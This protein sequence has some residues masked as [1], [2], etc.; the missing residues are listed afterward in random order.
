MPYFHRVDAPRVLSMGLV[1][2]DVLC[3][4]QE[5]ERTSFR[6]GGTAGNVAA[7]LGALGWP[8]TLAGPAEESLA[9]E[10]M[11]NDLTRC[12]V[13]Y[14]E[15]HRA[16][17][18]VIVEELEH[19]ARHSFTFDCPAC[20]KALP[21]YHRT[22]RADASSWVC[23][24]VH[25]DVFF[26][27]RLSDEILELAQ[28]AR[29]SNA[30]I[31]YEP[32]DPSDAPWAPAMLALADMVKYSDERADGLSWLSDGDHLEVRTKGAAG[33][34]WRWARHEIHQW[35]SMASIHVANVVDT[36]GA[37]DW[38]TSGIL[39][40]L[41]ERGDT[42]ATWSGVTAM[43]QVLRRAQQLAAWSCGYAGARG[44]LYESGPA[45]A[46]AIVQHLETSVMPDPLPESNAGF[47]CAACPMTS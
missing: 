15:M 11:L 25:T 36:C 2:L 26:A 19:Y 37:G 41:L 40:G 31:V 13:E 4:A 39:I 34:Q 23:E 5:P 24:D 21:R 10:L 1:A 29:R 14:R 6:A 17:V 27:D 38:L 43:E 44:A 18:P 20:G 35:Q 12:G 22:Y 45:V 16:A 42:R 30:F 8:A 9:Y 3:I 32:S 46:R 28:S 7:I 33:L 47:S